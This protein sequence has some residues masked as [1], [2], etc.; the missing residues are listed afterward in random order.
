MQSDFL[1]R[2]SRRAFLL[3]PFVL[4]AC[5]G[6]DA[7]TASRGSTDARADATIVP[8]TSGGALLPSGIGPVRPIPC[9]YLPAG[10]LAV[11]PRT[12]WSY[13]VDGQLPVALT[14]P[15]G[16]PPILHVEHTLAVS[17]NASEFKHLDQ[18]DIGATLDGTCVAYDWS[19]QVHTDPNGHVFPTP[20]AQGGG[21]ATLAT[22]VRYDRA[23]LH[24]QHCPVFDPAT[25]STLE[26]TLTPSAL[27]ITA[28]YA[29]TAA[30]STTVYETFVIRL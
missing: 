7:P 24:D 30:P 19:G 20:A 22:F 21:P 26:G 2:A 3:L 17:V 9:V 6:A 18:L 13:A 8:A 5:G 28:D 23:N 1:A 15:N 14:N 4:A 27:R 29:T 10:C 12:H 11:R 25:G 16:R